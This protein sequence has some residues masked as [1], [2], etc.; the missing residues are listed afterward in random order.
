MTMKPYCTLVCG[1]Q[2][3]GGMQR[4]LSGPVSAKLEKWQ[5]KMGGGGKEMGHT[6]EPRSMGNTAY[7]NRR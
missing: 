7:K 2:S 5:I 1:Y 4:Y 3:A 6:G